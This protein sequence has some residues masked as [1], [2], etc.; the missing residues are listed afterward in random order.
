MILGVFLCAFS[1]FLPHPWAMR[2]RVHWAT[3]VRSV[4]RGWSTAV[5]TSSSAT[6]TQPTRV[7]RVR[8]RC[9]PR[10]DLRFYLQKSL[11]FVF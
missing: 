7:A 10:A 8:L 3:S 5:T 1:A 6:V 9:A 4:I 2:A 11:T